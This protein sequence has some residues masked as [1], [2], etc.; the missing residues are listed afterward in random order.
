MQ[1][2]PAKPCKLELPMRS[3]ESFV[4]PWFSSSGGGVASRRGGRARASRWLHPSAQ[5]PWRRSEEARGEATQPLET[6]SK[7]PQGLHTPE[8]QPELQPE[9]SCMTEGS[10]GSEGRDRTG[11]SCGDKTFEK[12]HGDQVHDEA[13]EHVGERPRDSA[14]TKSCAKTATDEGAGSGTVGSNAR[15]VLD[16]GRDNGHSATAEPVLCIRSRSSRPTRR[17][18]VSGGKSELRARLN[19]LESI[20]EAQYNQLQSKG[21]IRDSGTPGDTACNTDGSPLH[22]LRALER[23]IEEQHDELVSQG[24][25]LP[26]MR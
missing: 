11:E 5:P 8:L 17:L 7:P 22:S 10:T 23:T 18:A 3:P 15:L 14:G 20:V 2:K 6:T 25:L 16:L 4:R 13:P 9:V 12:S 21:Y 26:E 19:A 1:G 24:A